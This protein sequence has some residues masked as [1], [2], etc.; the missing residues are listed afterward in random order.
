MISLQS[1]KKLV[2]KILDKSGAIGTEQLAAD[3]ANPATTI[4][5]IGR[6]FRADE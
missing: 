6:A 1:A 2:R 3:S 5:K 4:P